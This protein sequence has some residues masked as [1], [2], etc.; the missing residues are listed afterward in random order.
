MLESLRGDDSIADLCRKEDLAQSLYYTC[1]KEL[2]EADKL[3]NRRR[4][5]TR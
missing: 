2:L 5:A 1:S 4:V 3:K